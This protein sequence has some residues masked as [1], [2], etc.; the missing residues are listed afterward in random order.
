[1]PNAVE[2]PKLLQLALSPPPRAEL[3]YAATA[4]NALV[5][6]DPTGPTP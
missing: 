6:F 4:K 2:L 5:P 1:M 3:D